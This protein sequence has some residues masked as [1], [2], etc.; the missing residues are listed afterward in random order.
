MSLGT[1]IERFCSVGDTL[2]TTAKVGRLFFLLD[3]VNGNKL[4]ACNVANTW[5]E[6]I[7]VSEGISVGKEINPA[8]GLFN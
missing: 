7:T 6:I 1:Q 4:Y 3:S 8:T 5:D 2:P